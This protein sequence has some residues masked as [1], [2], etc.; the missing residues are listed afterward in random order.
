MADVTLFAHRIHTVEVSR[1]AHLPDR[2]ASPFVVV[3]MHGEDSAL[4]VSGDG[5]RAVERAR[6]LASAINAAADAVEDALRRAAVELPPAPDP[7]GSLSAP[8][9]LALESVASLQSRADAVS[10]ADGDPDT[11]PAA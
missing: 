2:D 7:D 9:S 1:R 4:H 10:Q 11:R 6:A 3:R 8:V 5:T